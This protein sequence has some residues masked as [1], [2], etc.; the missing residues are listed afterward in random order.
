MDDERSIPEGAETFKAPDTPEAVEA[1]RETPIEAFESRVGAAAERLAAKGFESE[2]AELEATKQ[3][4]LG[5][6]EQVR[7]DRTALEQQLGKRLSASDYFVERKMFGES[8]RTGRE[9]SGSPYTVPRFDVF[10]ARERTVRKRKGMKWGPPEEE[11]FRSFSKE[12]EEELYRALGVIGEDQGVIDIPAV[13]K[14]QYDRGER[15][16]QIDNPL[17]YHEEFRVPGAP[18]DLVIQKSEFHPAYLDRWKGLK[19]DRVR[20][21]SAGFMLNR[22]FVASALGEQ[23]Q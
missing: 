10:S 9:K 13:A 21:E 7:Q 2:A 5:Y 12:G 6:A 1:K 22:D 19:I 14:A 23:K 17:R 16:F 18:V 20:D 8:V 15:N 11:S 3:Q 4:V